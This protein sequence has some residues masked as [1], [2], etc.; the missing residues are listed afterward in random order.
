MSFPILQL[1]LPWPHQDFPLGIVAS[2]YRSSHLAG[3]AA[4]CLD[5]SDTQPFNVMTAPVPEPARQGSD[6]EEHDSQ[7]P[8]EMETLPEISG[9]KSPSPRPVLLQ[10]FSDHIALRVCARAINCASKPW[11]HSFS[12]VLTRCAQLEM[13]NQLKE[14]RKAENEDKKNKKGCPAAKPA[15]KTRGNPQ[16]NDYSLDDVSV[17]EGSESSDLPVKRALFQELPARPVATAA[18]A[19]GRG[20]G[21]G[22]GRGRGRKEAPSPVMDEE[23]L[24]DGDLP[25]P[26]EEMIDS[27]EGKS[28]PNPG[29][30]KAKAKSKAKAKAKDMALGFGGRKRKIN[31]EDGSPS[32]FTED[33]LAMH[34][35]LYD[36]YVVQRV[37][38]LAEGSKDLTFQALKDYLKM[39]KG[40]DLKKVQLT[41]YWT[42]CN[43]GI[44]LLNHPAQP[45]IATIQYKTKEEFDWNLSLLAAYMAAYQIAA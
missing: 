38:D 19:R 25:D 23:P 8:F 11:K 32:G 26:S 28:A 40:D 31:P 33:E 9:A 22:R 10:H 44:K 21:R 3:A 7:L 42:R 6:G 14:A 15:G 29:K 37:M 16:K 27:D 24:L 5:D 39:N 4:T 17:P 12:Q 20:A 1:F 36:P 18:R 43:V 41:I 2:A 45:Q 35:D 13:K 30:A 34:R